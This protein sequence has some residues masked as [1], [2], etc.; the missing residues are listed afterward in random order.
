MRAK[1]GRRAATDPKLKLRGGGS[2]PFMA[3][4]EAH[5]HLGI[6]RRADGSDEDNW[7]RLRRIFD[8][9]LR[10]IRR[11]RVGKGGDVP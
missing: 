2:V 6:M 8:A 5:K 7:K 9:A 11:I 10:R 3:P 4:W 1:Q